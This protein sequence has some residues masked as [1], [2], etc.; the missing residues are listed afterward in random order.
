MK[1]EIA[2]DVEAEWMHLVEYRQRLQA[3]PIAWIPLGLVE[4]HSE[5]LPLGLDGIKAR[6]LCV[7]AARRAGGIVLPVNWWNRPGLANLEGTMVFTAE[8][9]QRLL[10]EILEEV[11]ISGFKVAVVLT[12]HYGKTQENAVRE[13]AEA[14]QRSHALKVWALTE[15]ELIVGETILGWKAHGDHAGTSETALL[16]AIAP[17]LVKMDRATNEPLVHYRPISY[18]HKRL[19]HEEDSQAAA[20]F[21]GQP[22]PA[23]FHVFHK[24]TPVATRELGQAIFAR[25][26]EKLADGAR[27]RL[28]SHAEA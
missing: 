4:W 11:E 18:N 22:N 19:P 9:M 14:F 25:I 7:A 20:V 26:V 12:G 8:C 2:P 17:E 5:H 1:I 27:K 15:K 3:C 24:V 21:P 23:V 13:I 16:L 10:T 28:R 6:A